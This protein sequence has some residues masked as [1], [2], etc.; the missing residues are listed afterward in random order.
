MSFK[1]FSISLLRI[2]M[3]ILYGH[4]SFVSLAS[5]NNCFKV[6]AGTVC[7]ILQLVSIEYFFSI[8]LFFHFFIDMLNVDCI[9]NLI[10]AC[11]ASGVCYIPS[12]SIDF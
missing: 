8:E 11:R 1:I 5:C 6:F 4:V 2:S 3:F 9:L 12:G 7:F 10:M